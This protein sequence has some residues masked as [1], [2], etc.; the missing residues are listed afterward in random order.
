MF[1]LSSP[2][3]DKEKEG[4]QRQASVVFHG[5]LGFSHEAKN[6]IIPPMCL[7]QVSPLFEQLM[8]SGKTALMSDVLSYLTGRSHP[9]SNG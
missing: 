2:V 1:L 4:L 5:V 7:Q 6:I 8:S 3:S 9:G